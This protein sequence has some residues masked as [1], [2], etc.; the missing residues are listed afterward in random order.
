MNADAKSVV[1][2]KPA[3]ILLTAPAGATA[4]VSDISSLTS[5]GGA[6]LTYQAA[7]RTNEGTDWLT[8]SPATGPLSGSA[9][10]ARLRV[11]ASAEKLAAGFYTGQVAILFSNGTTQEIGVLL[12]VT[13]PAGAAGQSAT[14]RKDGAAL[15]LPTSA[16][17]APA[18][19][20]P[21]IVSLTNNL[22]TP[23]GWPV[24]IQA[25][26]VDN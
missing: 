20:R 2:V 26:V 10:Q 25:A 4:T 14:A 12:V 23:T 1:Q 17:C 3:S 9:D 8:V 21:Y 16:V 18:S 13:P 19:Q 7:P 11:T 5:S 15:G 22:Q 24:A 6:N